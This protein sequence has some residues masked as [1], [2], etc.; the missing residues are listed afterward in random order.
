MAMAEKIIKATK[1]K[2]NKVTKTLVG[3][4]IGNQGVKRGTS[5]KDVTGPGSRKNSSFDAKM[6]KDPLWSAI[7]SILDVT[8]S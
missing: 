4:L 3:V 5:R 2:R 8:S 6:K 7:K 1:H